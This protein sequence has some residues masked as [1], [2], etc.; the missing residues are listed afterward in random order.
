MEVVTCE[1]RNACRTIP[2]HVCGGSTC[3]VRHFQRHQLSRVHRRENTSVKF[4]CRDL[5]TRVLC[6]LVPRCAT[7]AH[8][9]AG[10]SPGHVSARS[11]TRGSRADTDATA[12]LSARDS[13]PLAARD[14]F[15]RADFEILR[16]SS[17]SP[18][19]IMQEL[20]RVLG[21]QRIA[22]KLAS[23]MTLRCQTH[24]LK[25]DVEVGFRSVSANWVLSWLD[26][27]DAFFRG[28]LE[29]SPLD[30]LGSIHAVRSRRTGGEA[31]QYKDV[32][33]R[34]LAELRLA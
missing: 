13:A 22:S 21:A 11:P 20:Q 34:L 12:P 28:L 33:N 10:P 29:V 1:L 4:Q 5:L 17:R 16:T 2:C 14:S 24:T 18:R 27:C 9:V 25:F 23:A 26:W 6:W 15:R 8:F 3:F 30:R 7:Q 19:L 31:W 32:C